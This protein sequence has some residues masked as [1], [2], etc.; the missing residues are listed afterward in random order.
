MP[1][2]SRRIRRVRLSGSV[3][4]C[5]RDGFE[6]PAATIDGV[7]RT[8]CDGCRCSRGAR[9]RVR[10]LGRHPP[11]ERLGPRP[12]ESFAGRMATQA[13][14]ATASAPRA[15]ATEEYASI[16]LDGQMPYRDFGMEYPPGALPMFVLPA[17]AFG[18]AQDAHWSP[19]NDA[20]RRYHRAFDSLVLL[21]TAAMVTLTAMSLAA[22]RRR[23][24]AQALSLG[25]VASTPLLIGHVF[26]ERYDVLPA[27]LTA[28]ALAAG[29]RGRYRLGGA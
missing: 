22:L 23:A 5:G 29:V 14:N 7:A 10:R 8:R 3:V 17:V 2:A 9:C 6:A 11:R 26:V 19:P 4:R 16:I 28:A 20:G 27:A 1:A 13:P 12:P 24:R 21:L 15:A 18:D 25:V